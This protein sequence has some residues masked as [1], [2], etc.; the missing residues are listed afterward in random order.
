MPARLQIALAAVL[1]STGG[2]AVKAASL[3]G[4]QIAGLRSAIAAVFLFL[5]LPAARRLRSWRSLLIG[6]TFVSSLLLYVLA[7]K[8]TTA[9]SVIFLVSAAPGYVLLLAPWLLKEAFRRRDAFTI[10]VIAIGLSCLLLGPQAAQGTAPHPAAGNLLAAAAGL[11]WAL[12]VLGLRWLGRRHEGAAPAVVLG[13]VLVLLVCLPKVLE[14][15]L[16]AAPGR[17]PA[18]LAIVAYLGIVQIGLAYMLLTTAI[19]RVPAFEA[20]ILL[21]LDPI[22]SPLWAYW[23]HGETVGAPTV[24]GG[25]LILAAIA[26]AAGYDAMRSTG[27]DSDATPDTP[28]ASG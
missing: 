11:S 24:L 22:L 17:L 20:S 7:N 21:L 1:F 8:L 6:T 28:D 15:G 5:A 26:A 14:G 13:N 16:D 27:S 25:F 4:W 3:G 23:V 9:A 10:G 12:T 18:D 19:R 2:T